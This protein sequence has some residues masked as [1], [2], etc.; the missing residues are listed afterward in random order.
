MQLFFGMMRKT[1]TCTHC[2]NNSYQWEVFN[3]LKIPCEGSTF[4]DWLANEVKESE[5]EEY[6]CENCNCDRYTPC[7]CIKKS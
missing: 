7:K 6:H 1:V 3:T 2:N 4:M 5:I